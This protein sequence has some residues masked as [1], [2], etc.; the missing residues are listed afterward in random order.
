MCVSS[1]HM[2]LG[3]SMLGAL[4]LTVDILTNSKMIEAWC[5]AISL[6]HRNLPEA[7]VCWG[8]Q[9][10]T[11]PFVVG[12][13]VELKSSGGGT[14]VMGVVESIS[15]R[16]S[17]KKIYCVFGTCLDF[18][19]RPLAR[20]VRHVPAR[21]VAYLRTTTGRIASTGRIAVN[22]VECHQHSPLSQKVA[23]GT[24]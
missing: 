15:V 14:I 9:Y 4:C 22:Q 24:A 3:C 23:L 8:W 5:C 17:L 2:E 18:L 1:S 16:C 19:H 6:P 10:L 11:R 12:D 21:E 20:K 13:R 7:R